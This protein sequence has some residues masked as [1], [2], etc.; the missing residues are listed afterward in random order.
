[1]WVFIAVSS[2]KFNSDRPR[3]FLKTS[4]A[5]TD[6]CCL[7]GEEARSFLQAVT[8]HGLCIS[9]QTNQLKRLE[10]H[11]GSLCSS[12]ELRWGENMTPFVSLP[13]PD[14]FRSP[15]G[16]HCAKSRGSDWSSS[17]L[18]SL[19]GSSISSGNTANLM[20]RVPGKDRQENLWPRNGLLRKDKKQ[21]TYFFQLEKVS[22][23]F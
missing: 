14:H 4:T 17:W 2:T 5:K 7:Q 18:R 13:V 21:S 8:R 11:T 16:K 1:M 20:D 15:G 9:F 6:V 12:L 23:A 10:E 22:G 19:R 3:A